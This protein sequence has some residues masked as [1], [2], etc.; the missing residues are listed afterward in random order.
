MENFDYRSVLFCKYR[1]CWSSY[2]GE[3]HLYCA[4]SYQHLATWR[5]RTTH[6]YILSGKVTVLNNSILEPCKWTFVFCGSS[7]RF[8]FSGFCK[9]VKTTNTWTLHFPQQSPNPHSKFGRFW[10]Q[11][12]CKPLRFPQRSKGALQILLSR[13]FLLRGHSPPPN[14]LIE[15]FAKKAKQIGG[16]PP[17]NRK[18][19]KKSPKTVQKGLKLAFSSQAWHLTFLT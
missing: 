6:N 13:F 12:F 4:L 3:M 1:A 17:L 2:L 9:T 14:P 10:L 18:L 16:T 5:N 15:F 8:I 11:K 19:P 7:C